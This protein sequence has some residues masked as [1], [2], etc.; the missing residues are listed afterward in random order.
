MVIYW[1]KKRT[2]QHNEANVKVWTKK[3]SIQFPYNFFY[4]SFI[5]AQGEKHRSKTL[6]SCDMHNNK[7]FPNE[8]NTLLYGKFNFFLSFDAW[9]FV[10]ENATFLLNV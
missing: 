9:C 3:D 1:L 7:Y 2:V 4:Q 6:T 8:V 5:Y 10:T